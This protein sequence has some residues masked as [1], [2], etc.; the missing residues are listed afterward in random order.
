MYVS[1]CQSISSNVKSLLILV[2][3]LALIGAIYSLISSFF[4]LNRIFVPTYE[5]AFLKYSNQLFV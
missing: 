4:A 5:Q 1:I 2:N 3:W